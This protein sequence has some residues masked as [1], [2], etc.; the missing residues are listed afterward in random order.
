MEENMTTNDRKTG[1]TAGAESRSFTQ[2]DI[3]RI[4]AQR[5]ARVQRE[6]EQR[7]NRA[8]SE[9]RAEAER[10]ARMTETERREHDERAVREREAELSSR[11]AEIAR[12]EM[13]AEAREK[14]AAKGLP[15]ELAELINYSDAQSCG[16]AIDALESAFRSA[17]QRGV[18]E[19]IDTSRGAL[20]RGGGNAHSAMLQRMRSAAGLN[21]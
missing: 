12:R 1:E 17:V 20:P 14:L 11:E 6:A 10:L 7:V 5:L 13:R 3:D 19:R 16:D 15:R 18:D 21:D 2:E 4:V 9:G 8:R